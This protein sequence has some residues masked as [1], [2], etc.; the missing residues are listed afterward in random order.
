[1]TR[2]L[3]VYIRNEIFVS[4]KVTRLDEYHRAGIP[5][6]AVIEAVA[7]DYA[8][9]QDLV[10]SRAEIVHGYDGETKHSFTGRIDSATVIAGRKESDGAASWT[11]RLKVIATVGLLDRNVDSWIFQNLTTEEIIKQLFEQNGI[12]PEEY[13]I[14]LDATYPKREYCVQYQESALAFISRLCEEEGIYFYSYTEEGDENEKLYF[15]DDSSSAEAIPDGAELPCREASHGDIN[16]DSFS[17]LHAAH[18]VRSGKFVSRDFNFMT[19]QLDVTSN[20]LTK[21]AEAEAHTDFEV[22]DYPA[23][24]LELADGSTVGE[25]KA[26]TLERLNQVRLEAEQVLVHTVAAVSNSP[27]LAI[28]HQVTLTDSD[29]LDADYFIFGC[30]YHFAITMGKQEDGSVVELDSYRAE[31]DLLPIATKYRCPQVT[32]KP[33]IHGPQT[34]RV[35]APEGSESEEIHTDEHG[36]VQVKFFWDRGSNAFADASCWM[37][38]QQLQTSGSMVLPRVNWEVIVEFMEGNPD[39]PLV[40]GRLYNGTFMPPYALPEGKTRTAMR[41]NSHPSGGGSNE[42]RFEDKAGAEEIMIHSQF[43][44]QMV[45]ANNKKKS[46]GNNESLNVKNNSESGVSGNSDTKITKGNQND[47]GADQTVSVGGN[48]KQEINAV[49][50]LTSGGGTTVT[51][52]GNQFEM[53][54]NPLEALLAIAME[55][56]AEMAAAAAANVVGQVTAAVQGAVDQVMGPVDALCAQADAITGNM[57]ALANGDLGTAAGLVAGASGLPGAGAMASAIAGPPAAMTP[58]A[59]QSAGDIAGVN[60]LRAAAT[61]MIQ[62]GASGAMDAVNNAL[63]TGGGDGGGASGAN[64]AGPEGNVDGVDE[65]KNTKGPGHQI[66]KV[67][68]SHTETSAALRVMA[69]VNGINTNVGASATQTVGAA[70]LELILGDRAESVEG[71]KSETSIG[72]IVL[73]KGD[74]TEH[75]GGAKNTMVGGAILQSIKG[76]YSVEAGGPATLIGALHK[77]D[78]KGSIT[79]KC[80]ASEVVLDGAGITITAP[81]FTCTLPKHHLPKKVSDS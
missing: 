7:V 44:T 8:S 24:Y 42:I 73:S 35:V 26:T 74:E 33:V 16:E 4:D 13:D 53:T 56:A 66:N 65:A 28:G 64:A 10:G 61:G 3:D 45:T 1:M 23:C 68:G 21:T 50:G 38:V 69:A 29:D 40:T 9:I 49:Y 43:D 77:M 81:I 67:G 48:R 46:V 76:D 58:A 71:M 20:D 36:R 60:A 55:R 14:T 27:R 63:G 34:A 19:P 5:A 78:A 80:G 79:F 25:I 15:R 41:T 75:V 31:V 52:G 22:Y 59:G 12:S 32:P 39:R 51:V 30:S 57:N 62:Q 70:Y 17:E 37:R 47:I 18:R 11:Y 54:G 72:L 2:T 6:Y